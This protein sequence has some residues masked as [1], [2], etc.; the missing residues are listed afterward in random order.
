MKA[1]FYMTYLSR[2]PEDKSHKTESYWAT[3]KIKKC[4]KGEEI[5]GNFGL[6]VNGSVKFFRESEKDEFLGLI[7]RQIAN[8]AMSI[9]E[10]QFDLVPIP[11]HNVVGTDAVGFRNLEYAKAIAAACNGRGIAHHCLFW[12]TEQEP[13]R[14]STGHR[15]WRDRYEPMRVGTPSERP[16]ILFDDILTSGSTLVAAK[17]RLEEAGAKVIGAVVVTKA[18]HEELPTI[19]WREIELEERDLFSMFFSMDADN[20]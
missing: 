12:D 8:K 7:W 9:T 13:Q 20:N 10:G 18:V 17:K 6:N 2:V 16:V 4:I 3:L 14:G 5:K 19:N 11:G 15:S 1:Y